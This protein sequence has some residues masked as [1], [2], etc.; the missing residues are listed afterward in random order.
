V[1]VD[2]T[3]GKITVI[4]LETPTFEKEEVAEAKVKKLLSH[5]ETGPCRLG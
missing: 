2:A 3:T 5:R 4:N 1:W